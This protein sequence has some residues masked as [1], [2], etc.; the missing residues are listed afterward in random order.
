MRKTT[1]PLVLALSLSL[2][3]V[4]AHAQ[5]KSA[6]PKKPQKSP[7]VSSAQKT[8][9][10][11]FQ[12]ISQA[13]AYKLYQEN[14]AVFID[15]RSNAQFQLG[16]IKGS[17]SIPGSQI[18][19]RFGEAAQGKIVITYCACSAEQSSGAAATNLVNHGV[20]NVW[21]LKGGLNDWKTNRYP[22]A[23]GPK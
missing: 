17:L 20:K 23:A 11:A 18:V 21:A 15:V 14:K 7:L 2:I 13:D 19:K 16:H 4:L 9:A 1:R 3:G 10:A 8:T 22:I 6:V 5:M 12:R